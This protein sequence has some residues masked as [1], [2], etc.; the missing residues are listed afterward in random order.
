MSD[1]ASLRHGRGDGVV[2][3]PH[4][5]Q[6]REQYEGIAREKAEAAVAH[7]KWEDRGQRNKLLRM[8]NERQ[9]ANLDILELSLIHI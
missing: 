4:R 3:R 2:T 8:L 6:V 9:R 1:A 7:R 5:A